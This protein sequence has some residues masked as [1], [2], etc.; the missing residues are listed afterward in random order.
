VAAKM[1]GVGFGLLGLVLRRLDRLAVC[2]CC[3]VLE[4][5]L[6]LVFF[7]CSYDLL[8]VFVG[9]SE[10]SLEGQSTCFCSMDKIVNA[11]GELFEFEFD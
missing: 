5:P 4:S 6:C 7:P 3:F 10:K 9:K 1:F 2:C 8:C 11:F